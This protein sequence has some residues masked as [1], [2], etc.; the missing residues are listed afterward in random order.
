MKH[1]VFVI[2]NYKNGGVSMRTTNLANELGK[3]GYQVT[4]LVTKEVGEKL[5]FDLQENVELLALS[6][7]IERMFPIPILKPSPFSE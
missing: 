2:G 5:F 6:D 3:R 7:F 4:I 1:I